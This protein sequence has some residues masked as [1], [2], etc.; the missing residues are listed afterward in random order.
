MKKSITAFLLVIVSFVQAQTPVKPTKPK[1]VVGIMVDQMRWDYLYRFQERYGEGGFKRLLGEGFSCENTFMPFTPTYTAAGHASVYTGSVPSLNGILGNNWFNRYTNQYVYCTDDS[2][3]KTVGSSS[4]AGEMSPRNMIA[5]TITDELRLST[6]FRSKTI[7]IALKDRGAILPAGHAANAAYWFDDASGGWI[8]STYYMQSLPKWMTQLNAKKLPESYMAKS[9]KTLYPIETYVQSTADAKPYEGAIPGEDNTFEHRTDTIKGARSAAFRVSPYGNTFTFDAAKAAIEG[10]SLGG[11]GITDFLA[12][13]FSSPDYIGHT[14]GPNS[15]EVEDMYLRLDKDMADFLSYLDTKLGEG[16]YLLFLTA[17]HA[18]AHVPGFAWE[19]KLP[20]GLSNS[21][22]MQRSLNE[23][24][25]KIHGQGVYIQSIINYQVFLNRETL[26]A[27]NLDR[28]LVKRQVIDI[29]LT[30]PGVEKALDLENIPAAGLPKQVEMMVVN[31][32]HQK[33]SGDVQ[34]VYRPQ[35]FEGGSR[36]TTHGSWNPY[37]SH[38]P[39]LWYGWSIKQGQSNREVYMTDIAPTVAAL[40]QIQM[41]NATIGKVIEEVR[42][43][44][45]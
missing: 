26:Q 37:D 34:F 16:Q 28:N 19:N 40:L 29:L 32:Y 20:A 9:W 30:L 3:V 7:G 38:I 41:P 27:K 42:K 11:R 36:G 22:A 8:S 25:V 35:W 2:T 21:T 14:F 5:N 24:L 6:N 10:E 45:D 1:L 44:L 13:S 23:A 39:L 12:V 4:A 17:D 15:I 31:G 33:Y 18:V 43:S